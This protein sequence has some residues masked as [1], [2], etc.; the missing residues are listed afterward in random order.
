[1]KQRYERPDLLNRLIEL[2]AVVAYRKSAPS[3][4]RPFAYTAGHIPV[5]LSAPHGTAHRRNGRYK[6]E[7]EYT[8]AFAR[9]VAAETGAHVLYSRYRLD[10]DPNWDRQAPYKDTLQQIVRRQKIGF[11]LDIHGMSNRHK[12]GIVL[13]TI[14]GRSCPAYEPL[15]IRTLQARQFKQ[16]TQEQAHQ[17]EALKW[18]HFVVNHSRFTGGVTSHTVTR[19]VTEEVGVAAAQFELC[20]AVR[21]A[22]RCGNGRR[23]ATFYGNSRGIARTIGAFVVLVQMLAAQL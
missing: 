2:E 23:P 16:T 14:N 1:M 9:L 4:K 6:G 12:I 5:L 3:E 17:F 21:V 7:D 10:T 18:D 15:I 19:F 13:G 22:R 8:T 20:A 11:V